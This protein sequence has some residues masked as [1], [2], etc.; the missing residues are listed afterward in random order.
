MLFEQYRLSDQSEI[1]S[2]DKFLQFVE[3]KR[4][5]LLPL[6]YVK[7][8]YY[9]TNTPFV[10]RGKPH[11][12][13]LT[14]FVVSGHSDLS[15]GEQV[16]DR[17]KN[18]IEIWFTTN[19][20]HRHHNLHSIPIGITNDCNDSHLHKIYGNTDVMVQVANH[21]SNRDTN[22]KLLYMNFNIETHADRRTVYNMFVDKPFVTVGQIENSMK[23][24]ETFLRQLRDHKF[25]ICP[26]GN[27]ID[28]HRLWESLYM[29]TIP[30]VKREIAYEQFSDLPILFVDDYNEITEEYLNDQ[31]RTMMG[32]YWNME[33]LGMTYWKNKISN[34]VNDL[35]SGL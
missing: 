27:G 29:G 4:K 30:I 18:D 3:T 8:D 35:L 6:C 31:Y 20:S 28:T 22:P 7:N 1:I 15:I 14:R 2:G 21:R 9:R 32:K 33:K 13:P 10:W 5:E 11:P 23:G 16:F 17:N 24:R 19:K 12:Q 25:C 26:R 34:I